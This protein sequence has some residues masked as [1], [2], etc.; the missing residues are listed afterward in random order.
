MSVKSNQ[1][2]GCCFQLGKCGNVITEVSQELEGKKTK[3]MKHDDKPCCGIIS[4]AL[5][6][7][8]N[9]QFRLQCVVVSCT[10]T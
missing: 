6:P 1:F 7:I 2:S 4:E 10:G 3:D 5:A 8:P 9:S